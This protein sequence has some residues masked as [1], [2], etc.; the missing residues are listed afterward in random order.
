M[1]IRR[2]CT[3]AAPP[4]VHRSSSVPHATATPALASH[5]LAPAPS[6]LAYRGAAPRSRPPEWPPSACAAPPGPHHREAGGGPHRR[7]RC[8]CSAGRA[9]GPAAAAA[10]GARLRA[11][12]GTRPSPRI[13]GLRGCVR[14][15]ARQGWLV[16]VATA[17]HGWMAACVSVRGAAHPAVHLNEGHMSWEAMYAPRRAGR[18]RQPGPSAALEPRRRGCLTCAPWR[19]RGRAAP[20]QQLQVTVH[21]PRDAPTVAPHAPPLPLRPQLLLH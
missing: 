12:A 2:Y 5:R 19:G 4:V 1:G 20:T 10:A 15:V 7:P 16:A 3:T 6:P 13:A 14:K 11:R 17:V 18:W 8:R 21:A 9:Q